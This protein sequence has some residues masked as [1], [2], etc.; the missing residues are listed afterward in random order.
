MPRLID[1]RLFVIVWAVVLL[2][3]IARASQ[4]ALTTSEAVPADG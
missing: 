1:V 4:T 2:V 3:I